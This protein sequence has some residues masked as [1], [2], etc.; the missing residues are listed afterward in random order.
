MDKPIEI[1]LNRCTLIIYENELIKMLAA[2]PELFR[3]ASGRGKAAQRA[4]TTA[5]RQSEGFDSCKLYRELKSDSPD[6][7]TLQW[8]S[9]MNAD[10]IREAVTEFLQSK[11]TAKAV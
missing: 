4:D 5:R 3:K 7:M 2:N 6:A 1:K 10:E 11:I 8:V 9:G